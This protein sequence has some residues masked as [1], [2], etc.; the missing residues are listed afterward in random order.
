[1]MNSKT[2]DE[3]FERKFDSNLK[4]QIYW[5]YLN[6]QVQFNKI[7]DFNKR[8]FW[9]L[10]N[11]DYE[12]VFLSFKFFILKN[13]II[14]N[15]NYNN[16]FIKNLDE[17]MSILELKRWLNA[18]EINYI[19][20]IKSIAFAKTRN[21]KKLIIDFATSS[22]EEIWFSYNVSA[23][24]EKINNNIKF[25]INKTFI[26][27]SNQRIIFS[28]NTKFHFDISYKNI[29]YIKLKN[30]FLE[31]NCNKNIYYLLS[32]DVETIYVSI[33]RIGKII[34]RFL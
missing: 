5:E 2:K 29:N 13:W 3:L 27:I 7:L 11:I 32:R 22:K 25:L 16:K 28:N 18:A 19:E 30:N 14:Y 4:N 17:V 6:K 15:I 20:K 12:K 31:I 33:E 24:M 9:N 1:M 34:K 10:Y 8:K 21:L 23:V 26:F